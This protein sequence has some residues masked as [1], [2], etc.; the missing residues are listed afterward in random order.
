MTTAWIVN[1]GV[2]TLVL[3][4]FFTEDG[5]P[6][7]RDLEE[8]LAFK[9]DRWKKQAQEDSEPFPTEWEFNGFTLLMSP[10]GAAHGQFPYMLK[11]HH[12]TLYISTGKFNG[13]A[14]VRFHSEYLWSCPT[15]LDAI[16]RVNS[17][18]YETF[19][20]QM[21]LQPSSIDLCVDVAGW[22]DIDNL[23]PSSKLCVTISQA[24]RL[25]RFLM[26][27]SHSMTHP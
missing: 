19:N 20:D 25:S 8:T 3:N 21:Y 11:T 26:M 17:F 14:S 15:L 1:A 23:R 12:I 13:I 5:K 24:F 4:A 2:D 18:L 10:N 7:K 6:I 16:V 27:H 9:L 22:H